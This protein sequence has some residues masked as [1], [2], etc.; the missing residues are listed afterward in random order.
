M[1]GRLPTFSHTRPLFS[2]CFPVVVDA[3]T[4]ERELFSCLRSKHKPWPNSD[5]HAYFLSL[6]AIAAMAGLCDVDVPKTHSTQ[7]VRR[8]K[9]R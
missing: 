9:K 7:L 2:D 4:V 1:T 5:P 8:T 3:S 6:A